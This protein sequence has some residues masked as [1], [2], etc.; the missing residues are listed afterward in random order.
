MS[1]KYNAARLEREKAWNEVDSADRYLAK[2]L[3]VYHTAQTDAVKL[4]MEAAHKVCK[5]ARERLLEAESR[6][7]NADIMYRMLK[8]QQDVEA[9][10]E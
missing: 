2:C 9:A 10:H 8:A 5:A 3:E 4:D 1:A 7:E 6:W